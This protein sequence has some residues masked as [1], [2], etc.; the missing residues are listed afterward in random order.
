MTND[1]ITRKIVARLKRLDEEAVFI[2]KD[3]LDLGSR[4]AVDQTLS[5]LVKKGMIRRLM[6]GIYDYPR[7]EPDPMFGMGFPST[8]AVVMAVARATGEIIQTTGATTAN[9]LGWSTQVPARE[10]Y[11]TTGRKRTLRYRSTTIQL[12][13]VSPKHLLVPG[14]R[15]GGVVQAFRFMGPDWAHEFIPSARAVLSQKDRAAL[16]R[17]APHAVDWLRPILQRVTA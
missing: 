8:L 1:S 14:T 9:Q 4:A 6:R 17:E 7:G 5:R 15:A 2:P 13:H 16:A 12:R 10:F 3:F 11:L